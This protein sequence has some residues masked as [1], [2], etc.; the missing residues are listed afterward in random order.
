M[1]KNQ[2]PDE[3]IV[4]S[5]LCAIKRT[6][7]LLGR[8]IGYDKLLPLHSEWIKECWD[9]KGS[10]GLMAFRGSF[11]TSSVVVTGIIRYLLFFPSTRIIIV[12]KT[13]EEA[14]MVVRAVSKAF[15]RPELQ[16]LFTFA[17]GIAPCKIRD[18]SERLLFNF[19]Q[20]AAIEPSVMAKGI[21]QAITGAHADVII[22]DD[23]IGLQDK[24]SRAEREKV[25]ESIRELAGNI[26]DPGAL[27]IWLGTKWAAGDGWDVIETFTKV[28]KYPES[29]YN[30]FIP[31]EEIEEKRKRLSPFLFAINYELELIADEGLLFHDPKYG[32]FDKEAWRTG[33][34]V[35]HIDAAY[36]GGDTCALTIMPEGHAIGWVFAGNVRD[37]YDF[38]V[39]KY[40]EYHCSEIIMESNADKGFLAKDLQAQGLR[41]R[42][43]AEHM[44]KQIK[45][46]TYLYQSWH[47][48]LW[49]EQTDPEYM[50]QIL[51]WKPDARGY[52]DA[53]DSAASLLREVFGKSTVLDNEFREQMAARRRRDD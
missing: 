42:T 13:H 53:P 2:E 36:G 28:S 15:D 47:D 51:D 5:W 29:K 18:T 23:I 41:C 12:R 30:T 4:Y 32:P 21:D 6:P 34:V 35:A 46:S 49:D 22:A 44:N 11:K 48:I 43:Y 14:C 26:V 31:K 37:W 10:H 25:K 20:T 39:R 52:D 33:R 3:K 1:N 7:H 24:I 40:Q 45:I 27:T 16:S 50:N 19:K 9:T 38:I 17:H 8:V